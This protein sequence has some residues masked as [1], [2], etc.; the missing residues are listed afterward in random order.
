[1]LAFKIRGFTFCNECGDFVPNEQYNFDEG[2]CEQCFQ[3]KICEEEQEDLR[4]EFG[5]D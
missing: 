2:T 4:R 3:D 1:M 5:D